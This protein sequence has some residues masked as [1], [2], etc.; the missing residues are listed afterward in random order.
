[1]G[2]K[3][4]IPCGR[5]W[6]PTYKVAHVVNC[7]SLHMYT[8]CGISTL[9]RYSLVALLAPSGI[10]VSGLGPLSCEHGSTSTVKGY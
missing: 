4:A 7:I 1:M 9:V 6:V 10:L 3:G 5:L 8:L 2:E